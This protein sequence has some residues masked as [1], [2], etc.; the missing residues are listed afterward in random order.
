MDVLIFSYFIIGFLGAIL[1]LKDGLQGAGLILPAILLI[2]IIVGWPWYLIALLIR[3]YGHRK[4]LRQG[5]VTHRSVRVEEKT[6]CKSNWKATTQFDF[7]G[8]HTEIDAT[9]SFPFDSHYCNRPF[10]AYIN[11]NRIGMKFIPLN[12]PTFVNDYWGYV[13]NS[14]LTQI[15]KS[16][17]ICVEKRSLSGHPFSVAIEDLEVVVSNGIDS[18]VSCPKCG[19]RNF[20]KRFSWATIVCQNCGTVWNQST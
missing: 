16:L 11:E 14:E 6:T 7:A 18:I 1:W 19:L 13:A 4:P 20:S 2:T 8:P 12:S 17:H 15:K 9:S 10:K 5:C 3:S